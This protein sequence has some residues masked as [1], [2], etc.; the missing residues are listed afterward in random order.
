MGCCI[1]AAMAAIG[2]R[3]ALVIT[4]LFTNLVDRA[5]TGMLLPLF[6]LILLPWTTLGYVFAYAPVVGVRGIGWLVVLIGLLMDLSSYGGGA[7][8]RR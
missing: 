5:F 6:G 4:W 1:F 7:R 2:P 8:A 3:V